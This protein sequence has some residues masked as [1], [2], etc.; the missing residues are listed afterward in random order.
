M[1]IVVPFGALHGRA[2]K[3]SRLGDLRDA[4]PVSRSGVTPKARPVLESTIDCHHS[5]GMLLRCSHLRA[6]AVVAPISSAITAG[7]RH[8]PITARKDFRG[9]R[10]MDALATSDYLGQFVLK[11]KAKLSHDEVRPSLD[12]AAMARMSETEEKLAFI[13]RVRMARE[14]RFPTQSPMLTL[15]EIDQGTYKQ[16]ETRTPLPHRFIP[17]FCAATGVSME[18]LLTG[19]GKGPAVESFPQEVPPRTRRTRG[20]RAA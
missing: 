2:S 1:G 16:Y 12:N 9:L 7:E 14:A 3:G 20:R 17:K 4:R 15:L 8:R 13:R 19:D 18:W 10:T 5:E 6:D 11:I